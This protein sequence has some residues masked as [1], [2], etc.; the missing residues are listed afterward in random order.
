MTEIS[1]LDNLEDVLANLGLPALNRALGLA[2]ANGLYNL[3]LKVDR[4]SLAEIIVKTHGLDCIRNKA[5]RID[6]VKSSS[7]LSSLNWNETDKEDFIKGRAGIIDRFWMDLEIDVPKKTVEIDNWSNKLCEPQRF[8]FPYQNWVRSDVRERLEQSPTARMLIHMPTGAGKTMTAM[9][10]I[11][12]YFRKIAPKPISVVWLAHTNELC[13]QAVR[14]FERNWEKQGVLPIRVHRLWG[15]NSNFVDIDTEKHNFFVTSFQSANS[16]ISSSKRNAF[17]AIIKVGLL[18]KLVV[19][20]EAHLATAPRFRAT[21]EALAG[22]NAAILGLSATPGRHAVN[23]TDE[24][25]KELHKFFDDNIIKFPNNSGAPAENPIKFL[26]EIGTLSK[27]DLRTITGSDERLSDAELKLC[28][29]ELELPEEVIRRISE[30]EA[31]SLIVAGLATQEARNGK[32]IIIFCPS[33]DNSIITAEYL[34]LNGVK[35]AAVTGEMPLDMRR[36]YIE[37]FASNE[38]QVITNYNVLTTG[39]DEPSINC[40]IVAR[41]T[42][43]VVLYAQMLGRGM[44]GEKAGGTATCSAIIIKDNI[45]NLPSIDDASTFFTEETFS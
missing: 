41:P 22:A 31:R 25:T 13:E 28:E 38:L 2:V 18:S 26:Q 11:V 30:D 33:K 21:T 32:K 37:Q 4:R 9:S 10:I 16:Y 43:S 17:E 6:L 34:K 45:T 19:V 14:E 42:L 3:G 24:K 5:L 39:F 35:A 1:N 8:P 15:K 40:V 7:A 36:L 12:D 44:R 27:V 20:D 23:E 29:E